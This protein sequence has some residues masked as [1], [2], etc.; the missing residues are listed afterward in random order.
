M[1]FQP[2][3]MAIKDEPVDDYLEEFDDISESGLVL[4]FIREKNG[5]YSVMPFVKPDPSF[6]EDGG[7]IIHDGLLQLVKEEVVEVE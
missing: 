5:I 4:R 2:V 6:E 1:D 3:H 7:G